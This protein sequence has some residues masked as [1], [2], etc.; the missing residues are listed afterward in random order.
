MY[1]LRLILKKAFYNLSDNLTIIIS[2]NL[3]KKKTL[4][5]KHVK[6]K[7]LEFRKKKF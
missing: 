3:N 6:I 5:I 2:S 7:K 4:K 1:I